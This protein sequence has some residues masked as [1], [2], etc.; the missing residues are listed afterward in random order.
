MRCL[1]PDM[2]QL[3]A[4]DVSAVI[5]GIWQT[6]QGPRQQKWF[7]L[8][9]IP[10]LCGRIEAPH[11]FVH[12]KKFHPGICEQAGEAIQSTSS[13]RKMPP[14]PPPPAGDPCRSL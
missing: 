5:C 1:V 6:P 3:T 14:P 4:H 2:I 13:K 9:G 12:A 7:D 11:M 10:R 8:V